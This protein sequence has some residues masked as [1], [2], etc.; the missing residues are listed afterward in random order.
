MIL[1]KAQHIKNGNRNYFQIHISQIW[2][3]KKYTILRGTFY[4]TFF[5]IFHAL[6]EFC[7]QVVLSR[8]LHLLQSGAQAE[9]NLRT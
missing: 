1:Q 8:L 2:D 5:I 6:K 4:N 9:F 7:F 3:F